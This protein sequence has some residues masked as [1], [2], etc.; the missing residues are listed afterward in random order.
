MLLGLASSLFPPTAR[1]VR[2]R[3]HNG[4]PGAHQGTLTFTV[5]IDPLMTEIRSNIFLYPYAAL[6]TLSGCVTKTHLTRQRPLT[7]R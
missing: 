2:P 7:Q 3:T 4:T 6:S 1:T 5:I